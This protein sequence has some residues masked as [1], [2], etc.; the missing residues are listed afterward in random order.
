MLLPQQLELLMALEEVDLLN[1]LQKLILMVELLDLL[2]L[3]KEISIV[4]K[5]FKLK[6]YL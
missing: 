3:M 6:L 1:I 5:T 2:P 4:K